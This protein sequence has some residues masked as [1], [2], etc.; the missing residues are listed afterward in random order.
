MW[1]TRDVGPLRPRCQ[2]CHKE[3]GTDE[4][5]TAIMDDGWC[6]ELCWWKRECSRLQAT[7]DS[8]KNAPDVGEGSLHVSRPDRHAR[9]S[10]GSEPTQ[11][12]QYESSTGTKDDK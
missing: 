12:C 2:F 6:H 11:Y 5:K 9:H 7:I 8:L 4:N 1:P 10:I 3:I